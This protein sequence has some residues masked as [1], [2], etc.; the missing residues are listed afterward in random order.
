MPTNTF[1]SAAE[2]PSGARVRRT[3]VARFPYALFFSAFCSTSGALAE[4]W[5]AGISG[6]LVGTYR[7]ARYAILRVARVRSGA[8]PLVM[9]L[10]RCSL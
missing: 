3:R 9:A 1:R 4:D 5:N 10:S 7:S 6:E 2:K 8:V